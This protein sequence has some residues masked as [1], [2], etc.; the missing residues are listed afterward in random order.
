V[1][2]LLVLAALVFAAVALRAE[3]P[4]LFGV[5]RVLDAAGPNTREMTCTVGGQRRSFFVEV[6]PSITARDVVGANY[7]EDEQGPGVELI[8]NDRGRKVFAGL[9]REATP[10]RRQL[11]IIYN[12]RLISAPSVRSEITGGILV[13]SGDLT[14]QQA[15]EMKAALNRNWSEGRR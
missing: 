14:Q 4:L 13:V 15:R 1:K 3:D 8:L 9:T 7:R 6:T 5:A 2:A 11:A 10:D 12:G